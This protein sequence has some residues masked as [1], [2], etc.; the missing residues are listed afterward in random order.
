MVPRFL[1][2]HSSFLIPLFFSFLFYQFSFSF[3]FSHFS[4]L[5][6]P[7]SFLFYQS[8]FSF[9]FFFSFFL[10]FLF[11]HSSFF[12]PL[13]S[14]LFSYSSFLTSHS[15]FSFLT[16]RQS[17]SSK[18][19]TIYQL[20]VG[21]FSRNKHTV[22]DDRLV[23]EELV[24]IR[25]LWPQCGRKACVR[26]SAPRADCTEGTGEPGKTRSDKHPERTSN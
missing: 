2:S 24:T 26:R 21:E 17:S 12:I 10:S 1:L 20:D 8:S 13:L 14:F 23:P 11:H 18:Y 25:M 3:L 9:L 19:C 5:I 16:P 6:P 22:E 4:Y 15:H 7:F